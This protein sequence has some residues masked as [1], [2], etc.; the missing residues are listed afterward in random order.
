[1]LI[2]FLPRES[3]T[4]PALVILICCSLAQIRQPGTSNTSSLP[5]ES[6][7]PWKSRAIG[8]TSIS[9][10]RARLHYKKVPSTLCLKSVPMMKLRRRFF[11]RFATRAVASL[12]CFWES[13]LL[14]SNGNLRLWVEDGIL[15][16]WFG[17]WNSRVLI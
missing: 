12:R 2:S 17:V 15:Q 10:F 9:L 13:G 16:S 14:C 8:L 7:I 6:C 1:M 4:C 11:L 3:K 5:F